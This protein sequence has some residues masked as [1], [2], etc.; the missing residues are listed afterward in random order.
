MPGT[1]VPGIFFLL[2]AI[3]LRLTERPRI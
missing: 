2:M 3:V 1:G